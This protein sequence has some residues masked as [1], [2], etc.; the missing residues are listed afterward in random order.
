M[1]ALLESVAARENATL[2][3]SPFYRHM[4]AASSHTH[5]GAF[6]SHLRVWREMATLRDDG[7][8]MILEDDVDLE[9]AVAAL[10]E[11]RPPAAPGPTRPESR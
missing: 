5:T 1:A 10:R 3:P 6:L 9:D 8:R 11:Y 2:R 7:W 4:M